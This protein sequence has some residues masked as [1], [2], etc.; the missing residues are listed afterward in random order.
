[1]RKLSL[2]LLFSG[3]CFAQTPTPSNVYTGPAMPKPCK[4]GDIFIRQGGGNRVG[5]HTCVNGVYQLFWQAP[6]FSY[7]EHPAGVTDGNNRVFSLAH[8]PYPTQ[9]IIL[10]LNGLVLRQGKSY[11]YVL[12]GNTI[13]INQQATAPTSSDYFVAIQYQY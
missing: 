10:T 7:L 3:V 11:D 4:A 9:S 13:T 6:A 12:T 8:G 2:L 1:M 5:L